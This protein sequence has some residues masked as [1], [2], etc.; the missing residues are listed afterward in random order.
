MLQKNKK[1][2]A[3]IVH[4]LRALKYPTERSQ[5]Q[6]KNDEEVGNVILLILEIL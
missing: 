2:I 3:F 4:R 1:A 6:P 5:G